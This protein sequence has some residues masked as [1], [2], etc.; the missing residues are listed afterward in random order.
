MKI[1]IGFI[2]LF[3]ILNAFAAEDYLLLQDRENDELV[4]VK[5][6]QFKKSIEK[7]ADDELS[8][9]DEDFSLPEW[10]VAEVRGGG[11]IMV[12]RAGA[13]VGVQT[14]GGHLEAGVDTGAMFIMAGTNGAFAPEL[15]AYAKI[16][17]TPKKDKTIYFRGRVYKA[18][19][20]SSDEVNYSLGIGRESSSGQFVEL[21]LDRFS[22]DDGDTF[23]F[24][25]ISFGHKFGGKKTQVEESIFE[26][27]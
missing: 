25:F 12:L 26:E 17:L 7:P 23:I 10:V 11:S 3:A 22:N 15:G 20:L 6:P 2:A 1:L 19:N 16:R 9:I 27:D 4:L 18:F 24:P 14:L 21:T 13:A 5:D 8:E